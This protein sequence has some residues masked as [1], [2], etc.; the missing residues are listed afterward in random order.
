MQ[1]TAAQCLRHSAHDFA[2]CYRVA[3][4]CE[5]TVFPPPTGQEPN[6]AQVRVLDD[7]FFSSDPFGYFRARVESLI[8]YA[9]GSSPNLH[10][11]LGAE[12]ARRLRRKPDQ[13]P[14][15]SDDARE[16]QVAIDALSLRQHVAEALVRLWSAVLD[17][18]VKEPGSV[19][20][21]AMLTDGKNSLKDVL[22]QIG[23]TEGSSDPDVQ[24]SLLLTAPLAAQFATDPQV[25]RAARVL[26]RWLEHAER[27][28]IRDDIH[29]AAA[30]NKVKHGLAVRPRNDL[31][32]EFLPGDAVPAEGDS[33]PLSAFT[34]STTLFDT[35]LVEY[36]ARPP[37][38]AQGRHGLE[39]TILRLDASTLLVEATMLATVHAAVFHV[40][41]ARYA[42]M[43]PTIDKIAPYPV[44]PLGPMPDELLGKAVTGMRSPVT[45][46]PGGGQPER[47]AG[48]GFS[49]GVFVDMSVDHDGHRTAII[50]DDR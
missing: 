50:A 36:L 13:V 34:S 23:A 48:I 7:A 30:N 18:R 49:D 14:L 12:Y 4:G 45:M 15:A 9:D 16:L 41:A 11:G 28:L 37:K 26:G 38:D 5:G 20:V 6:A 33:I 17:T 25:Q 39:Q 35:P 24:L 3:D 40:A 2:Y 19:S 8:A 32:I 43:S 1:A 29:L 42:A 27:L 44:L 10:D 22:V 31:R 47:Q 21:W 46:R